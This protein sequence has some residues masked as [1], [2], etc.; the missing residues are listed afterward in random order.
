[1]GRFFHHVRRILPSALSGSTAKTRATSVHVHVGGGARLVADVHP[2]RHVFHHR[3]HRLQ[4]R[5]AGPYDDDGRSRGTARGSQPPAPPSAPP[6]PLPLLQERADRRGEVRE[7]LRGVEEA[8]VRDGDGV[9]EPPPRRVE[10]GDAGDVAI[11]HQREARKRGKVLGNRDDARRAGGAREPQ[12]V[13]RLHARERA[14]G[15]RVARHEFERVELRDDRSPGRRRGF[16]ARRFL[17]S[18]RFSVRFSSLFAVHD[19]PVARFEVA[20][21]LIAQGSVAQ[22]PRDQIKERGV[23]EGV[24][25]RVAVVADADDATPRGLELRR[26]VA[27]ELV[28]QRTRARF[29]VRFSGDV[30]PFG[31]ARGRRG[32]TRVDGSGVAFGVF[33][34]FPPSASIDV[35]GVAGEKRRDVVLGEELGV[36]DARVERSE[37]LAKEVAA[38]D[39]ARVVAEAASTA[40]AARTSAAA[41][42]RRAWPTVAEVGRVSTPGGLLR[43]RAGTRGRRTPP[44]RPRRSRRARAARA[45]GRGAS[46]N[47]PRPGPSGVTP[48][49]P[50]VGGERSSSASSRARRRASVQPERKRRAGASSASGVANTGRS[51]PEAASERIPPSMSARARE[52]AGGRERAERREPR[53]RRARERGARGF[54]DD[55]REKRR[56]CASVVVV[57]N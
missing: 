6:P 4:Q 23:R 19:D 26:R 54:S 57:M 3:A 1:M 29:F 18:S 17:Y 14:E 42:S 34:V 43:G 21:A 25:A 10:D 32:R 45:A 15:V 50:L 13:H 11:V 56:C 24:E 49:P 31:R 44:P 53:R 28:E 8:D 51:R 41:R 5:R 38:R 2:V 47:A 16:F 36:E 55:A 27:D 48:S 37:E 30:P 52:R 9:D 20:P 46:A 7:A 40:G 35:V 39:P 22:P 33:G 12:G